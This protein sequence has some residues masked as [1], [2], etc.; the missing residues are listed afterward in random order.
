MKAGRICAGA[1]F[2]G[3]KHAA[4]AA[5]LNRLFMKHQ[6]RAVSRILP[7]RRSLKHHCRYELNGRGP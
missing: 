7:L 3:V 5:P 2:L 6:N 1:L 4:C